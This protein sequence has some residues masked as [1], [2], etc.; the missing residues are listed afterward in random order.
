MAR[1]L[2]VDP[3]DG[4]RVP[5][6]RGILTRSLQEAGLPF[7]S[8]YDIATTVRGDIAGRAEIT[9]DELRAL[10]SKRLQAFGREV[11]QRYRSPVRAEPVVLVRLSDGQTA[12]Y[13]RG[14]HRQSLEACGI[15]PEAATRVSAAMHVDLV[16]E[17]VTELSLADV[18]R[19]TY[20][21]LQRDLGD[22]AARRYL[23]WEDFRH[24]DR[25]LVLLIGGTTGTGKSTVA[26]RTAHALDIVRTQS[27]DML[28]EV[29]RMMVPERLVPALHTS[30]F[31]AWEAL[32]ATGQGAP[33]EEAL[34]EGYVRQ[35]ELLAVAGEAVLRRA[36]TERV[37]VILEGVHAHPT[38]L[39]D[40]AATDNDAI[41]VRVMLAVLRPN[42]LERRIRGRGRKARARRAKRY[43]EHFEGI[44]RL[45]SHL[46][47]EAEASGVPIIVNDDLEHAAR[48]VVEVVMQA[49]LAAFDS[50][51]ED[52]FA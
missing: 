21:R 44:W 40:A 6:L 4:A 50:R 33:G 20:E 24:G 27:T 15:A 14:R 29:M 8:A 32:P 41:V 17:G 28:R 34:I 13:S 23:V 43:L 1:L 47:A 30:S 2:V 19:R 38:F 39:A 51:P 36:V 10:V 48:E 31:R 37:S 9:T 12:P 3:G 45:Q 11:V 7:E 26:T 5:F 16:A 49:L 35:A 42:E 52:V 46:L 25:P 22:D 18:K